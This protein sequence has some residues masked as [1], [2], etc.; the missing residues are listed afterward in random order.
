MRFP[1]PTPS[2]PP[3]S[4]GTAAEQASAAITEPYLLDVALTS[5]ITAFA[6]GDFRH[7]EQVARA[8]PRDHDVAEAIAIVAAAVAGNGTLGHGRARVAADAEEAARAISDPGWRAMALADVGA[9]LADTHPG[10]AQRL[11]RDAEPDIDRIP[12]DS[13][14]DWALAQVAAVLAGDDPERAE[15]VAHT[16]AHVDRHSDALAAVAAALANRD[17]DRAERVAHSI[18]QPGREADALTALAAG[19]A[20]ADPGRAARLAADAERAARSSFD[21]YQRGDALAAVAAALIDTSPERAERAARAIEVADARARSLALLAAGLAAG[22]PGRADR[23]GADAE[24]ARYRDDPASRVLADVA[25]PWPRPNRSAR[26]GWSPR[27]RNTSVTSAIPTVRTM[28]CPPSPSRRPVPTRIAARGLP[29][30]SQAN[31]RGL[32]PSPLSPSPWRRSARSGLSRSLC[33][34]PSPASRRAH[35]PLRLPPWRRPTLCEHI[36]W[37]PERRR[38]PARSPALCCARTPWPTWPRLLRQRIRRGPARWPP[39]PC[40]PRARAPTLTGGRMR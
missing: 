30:A 8:L 15:Q 21:P 7:A 4:L 40:T 35:W 27:R 25:G 10:R 22:D 24:Q 9:R 18:T 12:D 6:D 26:P 2:G 29:A 33:L 34:S 36:S 23:L 16:V 28:R 37:A 1:V 39:K 17:P 38:A 20:N 3:G 19:V 5:V 11:A 32:K 31:T 13:G 14:R